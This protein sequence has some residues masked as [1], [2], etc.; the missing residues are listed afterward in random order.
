MNR[1]ELT[2]LQ[3]LRLAILETRPGT[4]DR[5]DAV[6]DALDA[7]L[8]LHEVEALCDWADAHIESWE[9]TNGW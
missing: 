9:T 4:H 5:L 6:D 2:D 8:A 7:G 1:S 3:A